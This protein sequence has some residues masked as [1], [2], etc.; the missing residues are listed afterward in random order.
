MVVVVVVMVRERKSGGGRIKLAFHVDNFG[1][2][3]E[4]GLDVQ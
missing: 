2:S 4:N 1:S 3:V